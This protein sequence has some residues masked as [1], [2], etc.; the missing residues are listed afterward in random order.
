M[1][2]PVLDERSKSVLFAIIDKYIESAEPVGSRT[3]AKIHP[4]HLSSATIRNAMSD[5]EDNGFLSQPHTS[6]G[7]IPTDKG[8]SFLCRSPFAPTKLFN[9]SRKSVYSSKSWTTLLGKQT[10]KAFWKMPVQQPFHSFPAN[11]AGHA[12]QLFD[13]LLQAY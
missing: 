10:F 5:L 12:T 2:S 13:H 3:V 9:G 11:R 8:I 6:A 7:R 1:N 4:E